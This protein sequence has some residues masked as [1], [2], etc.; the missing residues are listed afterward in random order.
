MIETFIE[1]NRFKGSSYRAA[2]WK[3]LGET[4]GKARSGMNYFYHGVKKAYYIYP[5]AGN[6]QQILFST[7]DRLGDCQ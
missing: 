6:V 3:C 2:N 1:K 7:A 4:V 5:L